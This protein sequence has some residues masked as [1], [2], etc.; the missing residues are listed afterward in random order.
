MS[1]AEFD[2]LVG[3]HEQLVGAMNELEFQLYQLGQANGGHVADCR[4]AAGRLIGLLRDLLFRYDQ[5]V[6]P[7][8]EGLIEP[9]PPG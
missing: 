8:L 4:Q 2:E 9:P 5:R 7:L 1:R 6:L 3:G